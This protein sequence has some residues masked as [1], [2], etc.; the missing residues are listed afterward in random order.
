MKRNHLPVLRRIDQVVIWPHQVSL[1]LVGH[2]IYNE[3][4]QTV[5]RLPDVN[6]VPI[7]SVHQSSFDSSVNTVTVSSFQVGCENSE[8]ALESNILSSSFVDSSES[9]DTSQS[10]TYSPEFEKNSD[11]SDISFSNSFVSETSQSLD[12]SQDYESQYSVESS[13]TINYSQ[14][15][16]Q[17][18]QNIQEGVVN[19]C[20]V[21]TIINKC[22]CI[23]T[24]ADQLQ[25]NLDE[26]C[27]Q[28]VSLDADFIFVTEVLPKFNPD[29]VSCSSMIYHI[30]GYIAFPSKDN[31]RG[32]MI[33][34]KDK[35]NISPNQYL[36]SLYHDASWCDWTVDDKT[37]ILGCIY[38]SPSDVQAC[39]TIMHLLNEVSEIS[40][41]VL[42][43]GDFN[44][45]DIN[46]EDVTTIHSEAHPEYRFIECLR[47]NYLF[48]HKRH[49]TRC[50]NDEPEIY[51]I[52]SL[53][54]QKCNIEIGPS[55]GCSDHVALIFD[56][57]CD[58]VTTCNGNERYLYRK[59]VT[60]LIL[61]LSG[62]MLIGIV[63]L[64][65]AML[66]KCGLRFHKNM[67]IVSRNM[68]PKVDQNK[69]ASRNLN[70]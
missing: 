25:N 11:F 8:K 35:F 27:V 51:W 39:E 50:R 28:V 1:S 12:S 30:D 20:I 40:E 36:N 52:L 57:I 66:K 15:I 37:I 26:L 61:L 38:R 7:V 19:D 58:C 31:G 14:N 69:A 23:Y 44:H 47:D 29:N 56:F 49:F 43:A 24:N 41:N 55:L 13:Q 5:N 68:F 70:G 33:Y 59:N 10:I 62:K 17:K 63:L 6:N 48:Q 9:L 53:P 4:P 2:F 45:R 3:Q 60:W 16:S 67:K 22:K 46:W 42:I 21:N 32:V 64:S 18:Q 34:A 54:S 65:I